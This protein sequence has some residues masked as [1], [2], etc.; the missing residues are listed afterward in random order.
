MPT[1]QK[2]V[3]TNTDLDLIWGAEAIGAEIGLNTRQAFWLLEN[4]QIPARKV[5]RR[6]CASRTGLR[7]HFADVTGEAA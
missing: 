4:G 3:E 7:K 6:W 1:L 2:D 5:G